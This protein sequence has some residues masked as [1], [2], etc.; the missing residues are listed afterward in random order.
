MLIYSMWCGYLDRDNPAYNPRLRELYDKWPR[1]LDLHTSGHAYKEDIEEM[2][3]RVNPVNAI[4]PIHTEKKE[5]FSRL[6]IGE[7]LLKRVTQIKDG[8]TYCL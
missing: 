4:I 7:E 1:H 6:D 2:I 3:R 8:E 5:L